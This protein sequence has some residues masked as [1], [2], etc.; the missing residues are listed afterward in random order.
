MKYSGYRASPRAA[1]AGTPYLRRRPR[2]VW[3]SGFS[4]PSVPLALRGARSGS[5]P[6]RLAKQV[7]PWRERVGERRRAEKHPSAHSCL[8][9][10]GRI[11]GAVLRGRQRE[12]GIGGCFGAVFVV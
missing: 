8:A 4:R 7:L 12:I 6:T 11:Q 3:S 9:G 2:I 1:K 5:S 10:R